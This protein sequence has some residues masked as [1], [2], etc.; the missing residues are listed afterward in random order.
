MAWAYQGRGTAFMY[1]GKMLDAIANFNR[2]LELDP[3]IAWGYF[4]RGLAKVYLGQESEAQKDFDE[5]LRLRPDMK[6]QLEPRIQ[7]ARQLRRI[8]DLH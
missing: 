8:G 7:L 6:A 5:C 3:Q 1:K 4:N 2:A